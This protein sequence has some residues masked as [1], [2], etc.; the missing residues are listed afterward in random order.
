MEGFTPFATMTLTDGMAAYAVSGNR[1]FTQGSTRLAFVFKADGLEDIIYWYTIPEE[2]RFNPDDHELKYSFWAV[3][4]SHLGG[5]N[6]TSDKFTDYW[7]EMSVN[8]ENAL[9]DIFASDADFMFINGDVINYGRDVYVNTMNSFIEHRLMD[10]DHNK[11]NIPVFLINGNHEYMDTNN[12][13]GGFDFEP[14]NNAFVEY[15]NLMK[16]EYPDVKITHDGESIWF[17]VDVAG[18]KLIFLSSPEETLEGDKHT[19]TMSDGQ[20]TF[21]EEQLFEGELSNKTT[22][23]VT[24]VP[25]EETYKQNGVWEDGITNSEAVREILARHP[26]VVFC[27]GHTHSELAYEG[28]H[29]V[30]VGDMTTEFSHLNDGC[31]V[32]ISAYDK[33]GED[34]SGHTKSY[35]TGMYLEVYNDMIIVKSRKF[36]SDSLYF[37]H[38]TY[39]IPTQDSNVEVAKAEISGGAPI[40]GVTLSADI[41]NPENYTYEWY[42]NGELVSTESTWTVEAK[43]EYGGEYVYLR[44]ID[45]NGYY[46]TAKSAQPFSAATVTYDANGGS[47]APVAVKVLEGEYIIDN[48][49]FPKKDG[50]FFIGWATSEDAAKPIASLNVTE[51]VT[52]YAVYTDEPKFYF[53]ANNSGFVPNGAAT[54]ATVIDGK[55]VTVLPQQADQYYTWTNGSFAAADYP[56]MRIKVKTD[57]TMDGVFFKSDAGSFSEA[58][59]MMFD[60]ATLVAEIDGYNV[61][62]FDIL[63]IPEEKDSWYGTI[64]ALRYDA[65]WSAGTT[66]TDY[67]VF[68]DKL[69][70]YQADITLEKDE[71]TATLSSDSVNVSVNSI[72]WDGNAATIV[73][74]P[75]KGYEFTTA[76]D[77]LEVVTVNGE[78]C[79]SASV[80]ANGIATVTYAFPA[81]VEI[82]NVSEN[83]L[84]APV[85]FDEAVSDATVV[86]AVYGEGDIFI[87]AVIEKVSA[88]SE[89]SVLVDST[90]GAKTVKAFALDELAVIDPVTANASATLG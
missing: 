57:G 40:Y 2:N 84:T 49:T 26:N 12:A 82:G 83:A 35:S 51:D 87:A 6:S 74:S 16:K 64:S 34:G 46:A 14:V 76:E 54:T 79:V 4:D 77:V 28:A 61:Y 78:K 85:K 52:L 25:L 11:N 5:Y 15:L 36:L 68:T 38:A 17:A 29:F 63:N 56:Y 70:V 60:M 80:D 13:N 42:V 81:S 48:A 75:A 62:E 8:R 73:L 59:H 43:T 22:F 47:G 88:V 7:N 53:D 31:M 58:R 19:Y 69:G 33:V 18:A 86:V 71:T 32:W 72:T 67:I 55:L 20:L 21:L 1:A 44:A 10:A 3:S 30:G 9:K 41:E 90:L 45:E 37:G 27:T 23:V 50:A 39:M 89:I 65:M 24:H 66:Y